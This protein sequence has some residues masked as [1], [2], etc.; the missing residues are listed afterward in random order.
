[1]RAKLDWARD[2]ADWP[3][4]AHS[5]FVQSGHL[6]W[7]VQELGQGPV[8]ALLHGTGASTH[9][10]RGFAPLMAQAH[11]V[12]MMDLPGH[13]F[14]SG[15][16]A[17][18]LTLPGMAQAVAQVFDAL[19]IKPDAI[20]GH[21]AGCAVALRGQIDGA[22]HPRTIVGL[23]AAL[24]PFPGAAG[25]I[26]PSMARALFLNPFAPVVFS[27]QAN[28]RSVARLIEGTG[29]S[30]DEEGLKLYLRLFE[31]SAHVSGAIGMMAQWDLHSLVADLHR[32]TAR[33]V[34]VVGDKD[35]AVAPS[36]ADTVRSLTPKARK[37]M[38]SGLGHLAHEEAPQVVSS[39]VLAALKA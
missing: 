10:W 37:V 35:K 6:N 5:R 34:L 12:V 11:R 25:R 36:Q 18:D 13:G 24:L 31:T 33:L 1:M 2:G 8:L 38:L 4:H 26:F 19:K 30:L 39:A 21:S 32:L 16:R 17:R 9:S 15:A 29:S 28:A 7:H 22:F 20:I 3:L 23:N 27:T 14:T